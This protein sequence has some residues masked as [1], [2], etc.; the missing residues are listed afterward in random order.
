MTPL[1][2]MMPGQKGKVVGFTD[3]NKICRRMFELGV[4]PGKPI[5]YIRNAPLRDPM[6]I[7]VGDSSVTLRHSEASF[8]TVEI[9]E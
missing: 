3:D 2:K 5:F 9:E 6:Q 4:V 7:Q 1:N 8:V